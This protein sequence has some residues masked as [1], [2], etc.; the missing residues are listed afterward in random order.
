MT[1]FED[2]LSANKGRLLPFWRAILKVISTPE[3]GYEEQRKRLLYFFVS[4]MAIPTLS[5]FAAL[6]FYQ[7]DYVEASIETLVVINLFYSIFSLRGM[8]SGRVVFTVTVA[9]VSLLF[10]FLLFQGGDHG[11]KMLWMYIFPLV[12]FFLLGRKGGFHWTLGLF[13]VFCAVLFIPQSLISVYPYP[14]AVK[15][16]FLVT[17][18][19]VS[20]MAM[21]FESVRQH[22]QLGMECKHV[23][24][25]REKQKLAEAN[26]QIR[27]ISIKDPLTG[28]F[29]RLYLDERL[30]IELKRGRRYG[31]ALTVILCDLDHFK[32]IN[33]S[34]GHQAGDKVLQQ[35]VSTIVGG[36]RSGIDWVA[37]YGGEEFVVVLPETGA[38][39][40]KAVAERLRQRIAETPVQIQETAV[41]V[42]ASFGVSALESA[43]DETDVL[44]EALLRIADQHLYMAKQDGRNCVRAL[45]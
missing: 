17:F 35:T 2:I 40:G 16:R 3:H 37:R 6:H 33:D 10:V 39:A 4:V 44:S 45:L 28:A 9:G 8:N 29:N 42:T 1:S 31:H 19:F 27:N 43:A 41:V 15:I 12:A 21:I 18:V 24:L 30:P 26:R 34:Y 38:A 11:S 13:A 32:A 20:T 36:L 25:V 14:A 23:D 22:F 7:H 5:A